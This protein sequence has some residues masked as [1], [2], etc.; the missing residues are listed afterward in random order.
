VLQKFSLIQIQK[1]MRRGGRR[2]RQ[3]VEI[4]SDSSSER[5]IAPARL[6]PDDSELENT[7]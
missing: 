2:T 3:V 5:L 1:N 4:S 6:A 7:E